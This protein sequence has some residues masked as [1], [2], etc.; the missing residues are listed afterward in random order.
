[1]YKDSILHIIDF[2]IFPFFHFF[3]FFSIFPFFFH[4]TVC[5][6]SF[7][8]IW[9]IFSIPFQFIYCNVLLYQYTFLLVPLGITHLIFHR[10]LKINNWILQVKCKM[11]TLI[12]IYLPSSL[13][14]VVILYI[15][16]AYFENPEQNYIFCF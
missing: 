13:Y 9:I 3:H 16:F 5:L 4:S 7:Y 15:T 2:Q 11:L 12:Y 1:M 14:I 8:T 6:F 10:L